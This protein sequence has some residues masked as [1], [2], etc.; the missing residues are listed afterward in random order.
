VL[1]QLALE[2]ITQSILKPN[3]NLAAGKST[4]NQ[5][6][7]V[8]YLYSHLK[9][10]NN[11]TAHVDERYSEKRLKRMDP[12]RISLTPSILNEVTEDVLFCEYVHETSFDITQL[13]GSSVDLLSATLEKDIAD[14]TAFRG[15]QI[16]IRI[17]CQAQDSLASRLVERLESQLKFF[18]L[19]REIQESTSI[20]LLTLLASIFLPMSLASG[21]LSMQT[22][23]ASLHYLL[24]DFCGVVTIFGTLIVT[25]FLVL[26]LFIVLM[27]QFTKARARFGRWLYYE[28]VLIWPAAFAVSSLVLGFWAL[29][30]TSFMV[31]MIKDI[32]LGLRILGYGCATYVGLLVIGFV[33][34]IQWLN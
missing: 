29:I 21:I 18:G 3:T 20:R 11:F 24:Y 10:L 15:L 33:L 6:L 34:V 19:F 30:F 25:V 28:Q 27:D 4:T 23:F 26:K 16:A 8:Q 9:L 31:G 13:V 22:R 32:A 12:R 1:A 5:L 7:L 14:G 2:S 17:E